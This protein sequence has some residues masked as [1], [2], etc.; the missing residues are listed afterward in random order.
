[1]KGNRKFSGGRRPFADAQPRCR[2]DDLVT[3]F[4]TTIAATCMWLAALPSARPLSRS[5][6]FWP[7]G[8]S[9]RTPHPVR[10]SGSGAEPMGWTLPRGGAASCRPPLT[11]VRTLDPVLAKGVAVQVAQR[12]R[13]CIKRRTNGFRVQSRRCPTS[14]TSLGQAAVRYLSRVSEPNS[15]NTE[16]R[17]SLDLLQMT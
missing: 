13:E 12:E 14:G 11:E 6:P 1:M 4:V 9:N 15:S 17:N 3:R 2:A 7:A 8:S 10:F 5:A 16:G